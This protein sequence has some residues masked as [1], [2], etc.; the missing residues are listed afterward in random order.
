MRFALGV[1]FGGKEVE[2]LAILAAAALV[3]TALGTA[4]GALPLGP[5]GLSAVTTVIACGFSLFAGLYGPGS[6]LLGD[7]LAAAAP[8]TTWLNPAR[9]VYDALFSLYCYDTFGQAAEI[10]A[11]LTALALVLF[12]LA[13]LGLRRVRHEHL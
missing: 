13:A 3:T 5:A 8:W 4:V 7:S 6:Q 1:N 12:G 11:R 9:E 10:M 2:I